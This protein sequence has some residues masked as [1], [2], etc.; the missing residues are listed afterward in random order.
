MLVKKKFI[1]KISDL[2]NIEFKNISKKN[3]SPFMS[4]EFLDAIETSG[5][6]SPSSGWR[7]YHMTTFKNEAL[8]G[9]MP[10][11]LKNN[12]QGEFVFDHQWS[13]ALQRA[14]RKYYPKFLSA[15]PLTP[16]E[17]LN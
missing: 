11:Y 7:P 9:F 2:S 5:S 4:Y 15:I 6:A 1:E 17:H 12:S 13:Y 8:N 10:L 14:N 16:C 3:N